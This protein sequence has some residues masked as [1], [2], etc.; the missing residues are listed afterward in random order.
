MSPTTNVARRDDDDP[1]RK[2]ITV[3]QGPMMRAAIGRAVPAHLTPDRM[4]RIAMTAVR[5]NPRLAECHTG[6]FIGAL[7][8]LVQLG[9]EPNTPLGHGFLV[10][11]RNTK[12][13]ITVCTPIVGY[14]GMI[15]MAQRTGRL[16][17]LN[18]MVVREGDEF[19]YFDAF[20]PDFK[21]VRRS[22]LDA[23]LTHALCYGKF[24]NGGRF[25]QVLE[26][27]D[28]LARKAR[29]AAAKSWS[30]PWKT[31]EAAMWRKTAVRAAQFQ[32]PQSAEQQRAVV[33]AQAEDGDVAWVDAYD[34]EIA[35][36]LDEAHMLPPE[37]DELDAPPPEAMQPARDNDLSR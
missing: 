20:E 25:M 36:L 14:K 12:Q 23:K 21:Y 4:T 2:L 16:L 32:L 5:A 37:P 1:T 29:S 28:V 35:A 18:A 13:N 24:T 33:L 27:Q 11:F 34:P 8:Q 30:S 3:L 9:L 15:D 22:R 10:P 26:A 6:S 19:E 17:S 31:D 7:L